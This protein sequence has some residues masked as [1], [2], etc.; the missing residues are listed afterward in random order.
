MYDQSDFESP[1]FDV[2][3]FVDQLVEKSLSSSASAVANEE[4]DSAKLYSVLS[5]T[6][7][8]LEELNLKMQNQLNKQQLLA[9]KEINEQTAAINKL[10]A[11][12]INCNEAFIKLENDVIEISRKLISLGDQLEN[13][14]Q[15][16]SRISEAKLLIA[17]FNEFMRSSF[18]KDKF[19]REEKLLPDY[20][21]LLTKL[22]QVL[23]EL[24][25]TKFKSAAENIGKAY[26]SVETLLTD[27]FEIA[28]KENDVSGMSKYARL[29]YRFDSYYQN[30]VGMFVEQ[31]VNEFSHEN[32]N[33]LEDILSRSVEID[34]RIQSIFPEPEVVSSNHYHKKLF[35]DVI[36]LYLD[37]SL[38]LNPGNRA[39]QMT[40]LQL[41][42]LSRSEAKIQKFCDRLD[43]KNILAQKNTL[44]ALKI[45]LFTVYLNFYIQN[46]KSVLFNF[47][48]NVA[49]EFYSNA[50]HV[51]KNAAQ[52]KALAKKPF[53]ESH[54][55]PLLL[56]RDELVLIFKEVKASIARASRLLTSS[57]DKNELGRII[58]DVL[59]SVVLDGNVIYVL[60]LANEGTPCAVSDLRDLK[61]EPV[62]NFF[63]LVARCN[64]I[65]DELNGVYND[66]LLANGTAGVGLISY[67]STAWSQC[68]E[69]R[70]L[71][72]K[73]VETL[74]NNTVEK[75]LNYYSAWIKKLYTSQVRRKMEVFRNPILAFSLVNE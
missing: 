25:E 20:V 69:T 30:C 24:D 59:I 35:M 55:Y 74:I 11:Q 13:I 18:P 14:S 65:I 12:H 22:K 43:G 62:L 66:Y 64:S 29:L 3:A 53:S 63:P 70:Q 34:K 27:R 1:T 28:L 46:E 37:A 4:F 21:E 51:K 36:Q 39:V 2:T 19:T 23:G 5:Q 32:E 44:D 50:G 54:D 8:D 16:H 45:K 71:K 56:F 38:G 40:K 7:C 31:H 61:A 68:E 33:L 52:L 73:D 49:C 67:Q 41:E 6:M 42:M 26:E 60:S 47:C 17:N 9:R 10:K 15:P 58:F 75:V 57:T 48:N 72:I